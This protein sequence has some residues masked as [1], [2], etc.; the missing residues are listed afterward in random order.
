MG[1]HAQM[2]QKQ[3]LKSLER[4]EADSNGVLIATG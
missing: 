3:R 2:H 4:F 1:L